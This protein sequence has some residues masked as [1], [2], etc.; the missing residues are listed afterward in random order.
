MGD[1]AP[2]AAAVQAQP[3]AEEIPSIPGWDLPQPG[4]L[5]KKSPWA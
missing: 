3:C 2:G 1:A 4:E 5:Y